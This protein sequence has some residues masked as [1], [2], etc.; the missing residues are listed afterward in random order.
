[1]EKETT[2][3]EREETRAQL[4]E[5]AR[6][7]ARGEISAEQAARIFGITMPLPAPPRKVA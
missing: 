1:M 6:R 7:M 3:E 5:V 4:T 2:F